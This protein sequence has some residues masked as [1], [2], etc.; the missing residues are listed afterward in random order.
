MW[1]RIL[2]AIQTASPGRF[3]RVAACLSK[4]SCVKPKHG[5][6]AACLNRVQ[7][8]S[9]PQQDVDTATSAISMPCSKKLA[10]QHPVH[11]VEKQ[12]DRGSSTHTSISAACNRSHKTRDTGVGHDAARIQREWVH[13]ARQER[14]RA[15][16]RWAIELLCGSRPPQAHWHDSAR[17]APSISPHQQ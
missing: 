12:S 11:T 7:L 6:L 17:A 5:E 4:P 2:T 15:W 16:L 14:Q 13:V 3:E 8:L 1:E 9:K 10:A